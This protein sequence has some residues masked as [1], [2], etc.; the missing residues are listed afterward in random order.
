MERLMVMHERLQAKRA[1]QDFID[2]MA[3]FKANAPTINKGKQVRFTTSKGTTEYKHATLGDVCHAA[4]EGLAAV[5]IS[6][7]WDLDQTNDS[8]VVTCVLTHTGGHS[9][10]TQLRALPDDSGNKNGIQSIASTVTYLSRYTLLSATGLATDDDDGRA[11]GA[12][13]A[14]AAAKAAEIPKPATFDEWWAN[15]SAAA[16]DSSKALQECFQ[17]APT[18][19]RVYMN[20]VMPDDWQALKAKALKADLATA[21][22]GVTQ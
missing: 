17:N 10:S 8:V 6:H 18:G 9:T 4:I 20:R 5:G 12:K 1:E 21:N 15:A 14:A 19:C 2:A 7:R 3:R 16:E 11:A 22:G 13:P